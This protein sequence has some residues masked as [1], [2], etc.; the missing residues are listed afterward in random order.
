MLN[1]ESDYNMGCH[2]KILEKLSNTNNERLSGYCSDT[3]CESAKDKI[4]K[5][6][7]LPN[8]DVYF[9][10]G[11]TQTNQLII[12]T[13]LK[14]YQGVISA[15]TGHINIHE[16]GAI[17]YTG[18]KVIE[19]PT[20]NGKIIIKELANYIQTFQNDQNN[21][22][23]VHLGMV[24]ISQPTEYGTLY[25]KS[26]LKEIYEI[27]N[28]NEISLYIDGARLG[29][30]LMSNEN[31]I[32][33]EDIAKYSD[34]FYIGGTKIGAM[35]GEA[36]VFTKNDTPNHFITRIKQHGALL[37]KGRFL[38]IQFDTL[39]EDNLYFNISKNAIQ[40]AEK[41]KQILKEKGYKFYMETPTN[42]QFIIL[43]NKQM[44]ELKEKVQFCFWEKYDETHTVV[45]FATSWA[46]TDEEI[47]ELRKIL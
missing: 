43:E 44:E 8:A 24:Y 14:P 34:V 47:E 33:M 18:H 41:I 32:T 30:A 12:D 38:G 16:A 19:V 28:K 9:L 5:A 26:E 39:F 11:G 1:F 45:R 2:P 46:T 20:D 7:N 36:I 37:A 10:V 35:F 22:H 6:C 40:T 42:Q 15:K 31:D 4:R 29:Y 23:M 17:E 25:T 21:E 3:Y 27:C 13:I